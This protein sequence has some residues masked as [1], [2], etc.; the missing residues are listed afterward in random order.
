MRRSCNTSTTRQGAH[1]SALASGAF[2]G[3]LR[4]AGTVEGY[5]F[6][7]GCARYDTTHQHNTHIRDVREVCYPWHPWHGR[8]V[9]VRASLVRLG[10]AVAFCSLEDLQAC[11]VLEVPLWMLDVAAC[12]K[13][14]VS[15]PGFAS[16][17]SLR[18][19]KE[20]LQSA[21]PQAQG[22]STPETQHRYSLQAGGANG[23][24]VGSEQIE[25]L[26]LFVRPQGNPHWIDLSPEVQQKIVR[27][28]ARLLR[29][30]RATAAATAIAQ[31]AH[32][33]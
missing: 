16:A 13:T 10:R 9:W 25:Q 19:L 27:L 21:R 5:A 17:Q 15:K 18:E 29:Q 3:P 24:I 7:G 32:D 30:H 2:V 22:H 11:R 33:E 6:L 1:D 12:C 4:V 28:V 26:P 20:V 23:S 31:E 8:R 14:S